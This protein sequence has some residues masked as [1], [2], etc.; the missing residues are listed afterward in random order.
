MMD[1]L[2]RIT[3][4]LQPIPITGQTLGVLF[5]GIILGRKRALLAMLTY[6]AMGFIGF[7]VFANGGFGIATLMG[8][9]GGYLLG[10][11]PATYI[12]GYC[13]ERGWYNKPLLAIFAII[14]GT[15]AI[16]S[17]GILWLAH[18]T[19]WHMVIQTG[20]IPFLPGALFKGMI[21]LAV[22]PILRK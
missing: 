20:M 14:L 6:I 4:P 11:I 18:F 5:T 15:A 7:P 17:F 21:V 10:F 8:P 12:M 9:S 13:G 19:G 16:F 1:A 22:I 2:S 3:N